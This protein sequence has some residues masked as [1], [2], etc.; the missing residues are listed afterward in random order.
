MLEGPVRS[1]LSP[2]K[3]PPRRCGNALS[4]SRSAP[5]SFQHFQISNGGRSMNLWPP[6]ARGI[7]IGL[8]RRRAMGT[9][10]RS[11]SSLIHSRLRHPVIDSDGHWIEFKPVF[12]DYLREFGG[13]SVVERFQT[14]SSSF[15]MRSWMRLS[16]EERRRRRIIEPPW[17]GLPV[18]NTLDRA[19]SMLPKLLYHRLD[20]LGIDFGV[21]FPTVC[22]VSPFIGDEEVRKAAC[23]AYNRYATDL[24]AEFSDRLT[25]AAVIPMHTPQE[26]VAELE[27]AHSIGMKVAQLASLIRRPIE[28]VQQEAP[29][30]SRR[31]AVWLDTLGLDSAYD[32]DPV[33]R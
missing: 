14:L 15:G 24:F 21:L 10:N 17:W 9:A 29:Q 26:A 23:R 12:L 5:R 7:A 27:Y 22:G 19:T 16:K 2:L 25:P 18:G 3:P 31:Y 28:A 4:K 8:Q 30:V 6:T 1:D 20:E 13:V 11:K 33:W 32:Y